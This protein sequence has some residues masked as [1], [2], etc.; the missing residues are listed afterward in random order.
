MLQSVIIFHFISEL[1]E[2]IH[3]LFFSK[4]VFEQLC[5]MCSTCLPHISFRIQISYVA[6]NSVICLVCA[7]KTCINLLIFTFAWLTRLC[8]DLR[9]GV[10]WRWHFW[11]YLLLG[12]DK[13]WL[14][15]SWN[16]TISHFPPSIF[17]RWSIPMHISLRGPL[18]VFLVLYLSW[19]RHVTSE[20]FYHPL[21][22]VS[23]KEVLPHQ[24]SV[25]IL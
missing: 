25:L 21:N 10:T 9:M 1:K 13:S 14:Y 18:F 19:S 2:W 16:F 22:L 12:V 3:F 23:K 11:N 4:V 7:C 20:F 6:T 15:P 17:F 24:F 8:N 5:I